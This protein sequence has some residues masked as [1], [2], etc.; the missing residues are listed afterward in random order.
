LVPLYL[1]SHQLR[2]GLG[3][4]GYRYAGS[5]FK[6]HLGLTLIQFFFLQ[7]YIKVLWEESEYYLWLRMTWKKAGANQE[8]SRFFVLSRMLI[9]TGVLIMAVLTPLSLHLVIWRYYIKR[10][11]LTKEEDFDDSAVI[12]LNS[13]KGKYFSLSSLLSLSYN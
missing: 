5:H 12:V 6:K 7:G 13:E 9:R 1:F 11:P 3:I 4:C 8:A 10:L 2:L